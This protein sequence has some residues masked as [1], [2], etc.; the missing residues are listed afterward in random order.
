MTAH[1]A[2]IDRAL[3]ADLK[4]GDEQALATLYDKYAGRLLPV[5]IAILRN[6]GDAE[7][8]VH[9]V[10]VEAWQNAKRYDPSRGTVYSW[11]MVRLRSRAIDR[12]RSLKVAQKHAMLQKPIEDSKESAASGA[13]R[14]MDSDAAREALRGLSPAQR[15]VVE[16]GYFRGLSCSE[17]AR[18]CEL[19]IGTVKSR[20]SA[21]LKILRRQLVPESEV[22]S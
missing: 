3:F 1:D 13:G 21:A 8:L 6:R 4:R 11:I 9:D 20:L 16:L 10:F 2:D 12:L 7:D 17:I 19:P 22:T 14:S 5:A 18:H 15:E